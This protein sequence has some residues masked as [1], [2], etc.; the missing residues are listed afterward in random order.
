MQ[1]A[2]WALAE[3]A[4]VFAAGAGVIT[5][6]YLL[7]MRRRQVVVPFAELWE[8]VTRESE[9]RKLWRKLRRLF[10]WLIQLILL[11]LV[12]LALGDPRPEVWL[13]E[14]AT[15]AI[16]IDTSAS[17]A[18]VA[19]EDGQTRLAL[20]LQRARAEVEALGPA[21][22]ALIIAAGSEVSV[23]APLTGEG[24]T[25]LAALDSAPPDPDSPINPKTR[26][27]VRVGPGE[28]D[29]GR[30]LLL[31]R[32]ALGDQPTPRILVLTDGA[33]DEAG[34][35]A[36]DRCI[37]RAKLEGEASCE[38]LDIG[39]PKSEDGEAD[40]AFGRNVAITAFAA[41]RYPSNPDQVEVLVEIQNLGAEPARFELRVTAD[42]LPV[43]G[44]ALELAPGDRAL[45]V[46]PK[47]DAARER[48][49]AELRPLEGADGNVDE[50]SAGALGPSIDDRA[51]AV[52]PPLDPME[53]TLVTDGGNL[54]LEA[55]LLTLDDSVRLTT[56]G[57][58]E[59]AASAVGDANLVFYDIAANPLPDPLPTT[60]LVIFDPHRVE[61]S[62]APIPLLRELRSPRLSEQNEKHEILEG[63]VFKDV[64]MFQG[65][66]FDLAP[67]DINLVSHLG[68]P[69]VALREGD[70]G[71]LQI[72]FDPRGSD[73]PL[74]TAFPLMIA[75]AVDYFGRREAGFVAAIPIGASRE[76]ALAD[77][78]VPG[79]DVTLLEVLPPTPDNPIPARTSEDAEAGVERPTPLR[80]R[81]QDGRFRIRALVPGVYTITVK[82]GAAAGA[83]FEVA[84]N[85]ANAAASNLESRLVDDHAVPEAHAAGPAPEP[86][87]LSE[88]PLWTLIMLAAIALLTAEWASYHRRKTV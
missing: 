15:T 13:R 74:R 8:Q 71:V 54:F 38:V 57:V 51:Y 67:G 41:R 12:C 27:R 88:G 75:N 32:N 10:S 18:A 70:H 17:M 3:L 29:L 40:T 64:N 28:A 20:A 19:D 36:V 11:A 46:L 34:V 56:V 52:I 4:V 35:D 87:P 50:A 83:V 55:A 37:E 24:G 14:P 2:G 73:L 61:G 48:L 84:V 53:V 78:G 68:E 81:A 72:G 22:R 63:V 47:L 80:V 79:E 49:V 77:F 62:P 65:T 7:R 1:L 16:V 82:D 5:L 39:A 60:N 45:E 59:G 42:G 86:A 6:L 21:D 66:S 58:D 33:L 30:A 23:P 26:P 44:K 31:A 85:Q 25:L 69:I 43:G 9:S 76:L